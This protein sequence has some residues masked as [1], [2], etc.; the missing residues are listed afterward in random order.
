MA[1]SCYATEGGNGPEVLQ[2]Q[3]WLQGREIFLL[4]DSGST[5]SFVSQA[6]AE[7]LTG[8]KPLKQ[9]IRVKVADGAE[10]QCTQEIPQCKW[11]V[12][13]WV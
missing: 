12:Y 10:L 5:T 1:L 4:I 13:P 6:L 8:L 9:R 7:S 3:A 11:V 2:L